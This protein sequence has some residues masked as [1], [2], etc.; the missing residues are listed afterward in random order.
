MLFRKVHVHTRKYGIPLNLTSPSVLFSV[1][2][3]SGSVSI[4]SASPLD[5]TM[6]HHNIQFGRRGR[7]GWLRVD[8]GQTTKGRSPG[9]LTAL[10]TDGILYVGGTDVSVSGQL[11]IQTQLGV[12]FRGKYKNIFTETLFSILWTINQYVYA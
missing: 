7:D 6:S 12:E 10:D 5:V 2:F 3:L 8:Y 11:K 9:V 4:W 1:S